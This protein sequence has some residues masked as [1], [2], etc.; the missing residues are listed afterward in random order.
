MRPRIA[1]LVGTCTLALTITACGTQAGPSKILGS[2]P[3]PTVK[4]AAANAYLTAANAYNAAVDTGG[5]LC[6]GTSSTNAQLKACYTA[7][8]NADQVF[9]K[10]LFAITFPPGM[11]ADVNAIISADAAETIA[12]CGIATSPDPNADYSD[13]A[14]ST[15]AGNAA[16]AAASIVRHDLGLPPITVTA[17]SPS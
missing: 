5:R 4:E 7:F 2:K 3:T 8:C 10:A 6:P 1:I 12:D 17:P 9:Q 16:A 15:A 13:F 14:A 11:K